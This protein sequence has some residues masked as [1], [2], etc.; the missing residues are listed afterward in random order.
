[1][2]SQLNKPKKYVIGTQIKFSLKRRVC[3]E[4]PKWFKENRFTYSL[5]IYFLGYPVFN[6]FCE[7]LQLLVRETLSR[8]YCF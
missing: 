8:Q 2:V 5:Y 6:A 3:S 1:M 7:K 4:V